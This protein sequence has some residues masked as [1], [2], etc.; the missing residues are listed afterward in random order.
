[1]VQ[2]VI[3]AGIPLLAVVVREVPLA[4]IVKWIVG[5]IL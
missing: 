5:K 2:L 1:V 4:D 3:A